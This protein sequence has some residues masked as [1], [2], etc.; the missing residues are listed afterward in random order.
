MALRPFVISSSNAKNALASLFKWTL[1]S[2]EHLKTTVASKNEEKEDIKLAPS[3][4]KVVFTI[5]NALN[6]RIEIDGTSNR[7]SRQF[8]K[9]Y[10]RRRW[11]FRI[12]I[13]FFAG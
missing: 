7:E 12:P 6:G 9:S 4:V 5:W 8:V 10:R 11:L 1:Y 2:Q 3:A 13:S